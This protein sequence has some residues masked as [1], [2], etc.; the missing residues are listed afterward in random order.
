MVSKKIAFGS[1]E[2]RTATSAV[3]DELGNLSVGA[4]ED[5]A[6]LRMQE[7]KFGFVD[8]NNAGFPGSRKLVCELTIHNG[9]VV[10]DLNGMT[11]DRWDGPRLSPAQARRFTTMHVEQAH[12]VEVH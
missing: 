2:G 4:P 12:P 3:D 11:A 1:E 8:M 7:G 10:Y 5:I 6:V 9:K